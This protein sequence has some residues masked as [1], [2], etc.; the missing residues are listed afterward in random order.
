[1]KSHAQAV[2]IGGG[3][4]GCSVLYH[5]VKLGWRDVVLLERS[6][7]TAGSTWHAA[8]GMHTLNGD[9]S[10]AALQAYTIDL[11]REIERE[12][13]IACGI[14]QTGSLYLATTERE[15]DFFRSEQSKAR[16]L[17][18]ALDFIELS[19]ARRLNPLIETTDYRAAMFD[20]HDGHVDPSGVTLAYAQAARNGGA[21]IYKHTPVTALTPLAD[22]GWQVQTPKGDIHAEYIV[23][24]AGLWAREVGRL[25]QCELPI[26]PMEHQYIVTNDIPELAALGREIPA[27]VDF[28]GAAYLRQERHGLLL[29]T[30]EQY[31][32][33]WAVNGT[34]LDF[35]V[36]LLPPD[37]ERIVEPLDRVMDRMPAL[38]RAGIKRIVNGG[39]VFAPDGNPII[40]P[41]PGHRTA[42]V[43]AGVMAGF[44]QGGGVGLAVA[45]WMVDGEP[46][47]DVFAMDVARFGDFAN[48]AYV[49]E[50]T[51]ENYQRRFIL[52]C[53]NE[54]LP[55]AR[56]TKTTPIYDLLHDAGAVFGAAAGWEVPLWFADSPANAVEAPSFRRSSA[57]DAIGEE[58]QAVRERVGLWETSSYCKIEVS[59]PGTAEWLDALVANRLP[60]LGRVTLSPM[61]TPAGRV[62]GDVTLVRLAADRLLIMG[63]PFAESVYLRWLHHQ[64]DGA[65]VHITSRTNELCGLSLSGPLSRE[66]LQSVC[67]SD[68]SNISFPFLTCRELSIGRASVWAMRL[69]FTGECGYEL[70]MPPPYQRHVYELLLREGRRYGLKQFGVRALNSLRL[71]KGYGSWGREYTQDFSAAEAGLERFVRMDKARCIGLE[72]ARSQKEAAPQRQLRLLAIDSTNPDPGG[73][74]PVL[75]EGN[76]VARLTSATY[77]YTVKHSLGFAYLPAGIGPAETGLEVELC[78][79]RVS[80]RVLQSPPYDPTGARLRC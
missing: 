32:R 4:V 68:L 71:E 74:E 80:A 22:G 75:C 55:A 8:G 79:T 9:P 63:S 39:M 1:M 46:G 44:S 70:Y 10:V 13:G 72:A 34:P 45:H 59:G 36:E 65:D 28:D 54:E 61:L 23:N 41:L 37:L 31:C 30:Y 35:G 3:V 2:V 20:P 62:L 7:L 64:A 78:G 56:P 43:A 73:G 29:G 52:P 57:F 76:A 27:A 15:L 11:Y 42:F 26:I 6:E 66:L 24:A 12:S 21:E 17:G 51:R 25:M 53:P 14:H 5:L 77:G 33:H 58:C 60:A 48:P 69:S 67:D 19:E 18:T 40:G 38:G 49:R 50:K 47:M 16:H